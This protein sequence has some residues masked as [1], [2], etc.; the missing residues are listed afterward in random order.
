MAAGLVG[1]WKSFTTF[2]DNSLTLYEVKLKRDGVR[3]EIGLL[4]WFGR[5]TKYNKFT[6][7]I[8]DL[9]PPP[10]HSDSVPLKGDLFP[11]MA[12]V[13]EIKSENP[14][15]PWIKYYDVIRKKFYI[16]KDYAYMDRELMVAVMNGFYIK[17][18]K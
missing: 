13:F 9:A 18:Q 7:D 10:L 11:H 4:D 5:T 12:E 1:L 16:H 2:A 8:K 17:T 3:I 14:N 15:I 6:I